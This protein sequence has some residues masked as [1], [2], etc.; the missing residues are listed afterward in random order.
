MVTLCL[1][2]TERSLPGPVSFTASTSAAATFDDD[3]GLGN[4]D[5]REA[6]SV[7]TTEL[8]QHCV[9]SSPRYTGSTRQ[10]TPGSYRCHRVTDGRKPDGL[11]GCGQL[12]IARDHDQVLDVQ[13]DGS[14]ELDCVIGPQGHFF[15]QV[16]GPCHQVPPGLL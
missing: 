12:P 7:V 3:P 4:P 14:S 8:D 11:R 15:G 16:P 9:K 5:E 13:G 1:Q 2:Q 10:S 6:T